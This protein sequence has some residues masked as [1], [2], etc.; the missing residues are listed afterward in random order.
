M[1]ALSAAPGRPASTSCTSGRS[2][3]PVG[4]V[5]PSSRSSR[6]LS[7]QVHQQRRGRRPAP[8]VSGAACA[9][10]K[11]SMKQVV[12]EQAA[13]AAPAQLAERAAS[14]AVGIAGA[15][16]AGPSDGA[17]HH[18]LLD[19]ADRLR[20]VQPLRADVDAVHDRVAAEQA[21]R[22]LEVVEPL[23]GRLVA[24]VGDEAV[25]LQQAGRADELVGVPPEARAAGR[26]ARAQ[27]ALVQ[28]VQ[29]VA[30]L[31]RLQALLLGRQR[32]R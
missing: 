30:L 4:F 2:S 29:L 8:A 13:P 24:A 3:S 21:V 19:L 22:I 32:R 15:T 16:S 28:A 20:R 10:K 6:S 11:R 18:Q 31:G 12:L 17:P 5:R 7:A 1:R 25:G 9:A 27:D 26:A 14:S 23:A